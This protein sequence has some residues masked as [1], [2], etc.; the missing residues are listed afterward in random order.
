MGTFGAVR[1]WSRTGSFQMSHV[2]DR[3]MR[4]FSALSVT[5]VDIFGCVSVTLL[6]A[7]IAAAA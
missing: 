6:A 4:I 5:Y 2:D 1:F 7:Y 3:E